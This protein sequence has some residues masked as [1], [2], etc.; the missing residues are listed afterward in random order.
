MP[1]SNLPKKWELIGKKKNNILNIWIP[2]VQ[3]IFL[4]DPVVDLFFVILI[5]ACGYICEHRTTMGH[6]KFVSIVVCSSSGFVIVKNVVKNVN[7][8]LNSM[9]NICCLIC[10]NQ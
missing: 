2:I 1:P 5:P 3:R 7:A 8:C 4:I 9:R 6:L 10:E